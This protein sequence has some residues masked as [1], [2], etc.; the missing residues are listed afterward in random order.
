[1]NAPAYNFAF[2]PVVHDLDAWAD[3]KS[4]GYQRPLTGFRDIHMPRNT[5]AGVIMAGLSVVLAV[6]LI[7]YI[8]WLA[9]V[10]FVALIGYTIA[11]TFNYDRDFLI[12][13]S[14]VT[15]VEDERTRLLAANAQ[16]G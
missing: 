9:I 5:G 7:W 11:H 16:A 4:R 2:T 14:D 6:A 1:M 12:P 8:W 3:M 10:S 13:S 15:R